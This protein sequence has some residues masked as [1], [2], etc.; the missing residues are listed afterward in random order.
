[1][2]AVT[3]EL[4]P[5]SQTTYAGRPFT[6]DLYA[7]ANPSQSIGVVNVVLRWDPTFLTLL[8]QDADG[9]VPW[10]T[11][12]FPTGGLN[13][14]FSDGDAFFTAN[15]APC[16]PTTIT[17]GGVRLTTL[18]FVAG[19]TPGTGQASASAS[20]GGFQS[21]A[22]DN[23]TIL[24]CNGQPVAVSVGPAVNI[25][26]NACISSLNCNDGDACSADACSGGVCTYSPN[27]NALTHCCNPA[28]GAQTLINDGN[29]C[30]N[31]LCDS[32]TG[33]VTHSNKTFGSA[34]GSQVQNSCTNP[35]TC[36][37]SG[38]CLANNTTN[39]APCDDG[40]TCSQS[41]S[42]QGGVCTGANPRPNGTACSD[43]LDCTSG[44]G[45]CS[46]GKCIEP[47]AVCGG[48]TPFCIETPTC[49]GSA[50]CGAQGP[51]TGGIC[52]AGYVCWGCL[53]EPKP[54]TSNADC[55]SS[56][57]CENSVC[58][59]CA[60]D[61]GC[62]TRYCSPFSH[63]CINVRHHDQCQDSVFC[64]G[65]E[66]CDIF[67]S[68]QPANPPEA[69]CPPGTVCN[70][71]GDDC[72]ECVDTSNCPTG[73]YCNTAAHICVD[74]L[75]NAHCN[76]GNSCNGIET[77]NI[78]SGV[79]VAGSPVVCSQTQICTINVCNPSNGLCEPRAAE[80]VSCS[81]QNPCPQGFICGPS[82]FCVPGMSCTDNNGC[83]VSDT[84]QNGACVGQP[85]ASNGPVNLRLAPAAGAVFT[86]GQ[87]VEVRYSLLAPT[88]AQ[89][90]NTAEANLQWDQ[91]RLSLQSPGFVDPCT[92]HS[93]NP[94]ACPAGQYDWFSSGFLANLDL[95]GLN[96]SFTDGNAHYSA[97]IGPGLPDAPV[98]PST[99]L[100]VTSFK[101]TA[102]GAT[103]STG[104]Q[105]SLVRCTGP[106]GTFSRVSAG[107][108]NDLTG[109]FISTTINIQCSNNNQC[110]D[111]NACTIDSCNLGTQYCQYTNSANGI[112]CGNQTPT[113]NCDLPDIC[114]A[115]VCNP[116]HTSCADD[117]NPC[118]DDVC[119]AAT[120]NCVRPSKPNGTPCNDGQ[121]CTTG[122]TCS[123]GACG[124]GQPRTC[125]DSFS[126]TIDSCNESNDSCVH[127]PDD[128]AC[129][130][131]LFCN[132]Q[133]SCSVTQGCI[134]GTPPN[135]T[136]DGIACTQ[137]DFCNESL[138]LCDGVPNN[139]LCP[140]GQIC[141]ALIGCLTTNC[142]PPLA[143]SA[144]PRY[145]VVTPQP[146]G[147]TSPQ[148]LNIDSLTWTCLSKYVG[149]PV[150]VDIN[151]DGVIDGKAAK[152][153]DDPG[154]AA[155][156][157]PAQWGGTVYIT[158]E[159]IVPTDRIPGGNPPISE[160]TYRVTADCG[161]GEFSLP[162][163]VT[164][165]FWA[166]ADHNGVVNFTDVSLAVQ[167]FL[168]R[169]GLPPGSNPGSTKLSV[170]LV[171][172]VPC[173]PPVP[174]LVN[175][176]DIS[177]HIRSF[178]GI[179]YQATILGLPPGDGCMMPCP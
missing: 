94:L 3:F 117:G 70:E 140:S 134:A 55:P 52:A 28:T 103:S 90:I 51:C 162:T 101:F 65:D 136:S 165:D 139:T 105:V 86:I 16:T 31:D 95:D 135:C 19:T 78:S 96:D 146:V 2:A 35:D 128:G 8:G 98:S 160:S 175:F 66:V 112:A 14:S 80:I 46:G 9:A 23:L 75:S 63:V 58:R 11:A 36:D 21:A 29:S 99:P 26:I 88:T 41:S 13:A 178:Q 123:A 24:N 102:T 44:A 34:C 147:S 85:P 15:V 110:N 5:S 87:T 69:D 59:N 108:G 56:R 156:L 100:W 124:G 91:A 61:A 166:D 27:Y 38:N 17:A 10:Q 107:S 163:P 89:N 158:G 25:T 111:G 169:F 74:C 64:N 143:R 133:E 49:A 131:Y 7:V 125:S 152:L 12:G 48:S 72:V 148:A 47:N 60:A 116:N 119:D 62:V 57:P 22:W 149:T 150:D 127:T 120:G 118:T 154:N 168:G 164:M 132:G 4:R 53:P 18:E 106:N 142:P 45:T 37:A 68:C 161:A 171:G 153:V 20:F 172:I 82:G 104:T 174:P 170:D 6:I 114:M 71:A 1:M 137:N 84:C 151:G 81:Q 77:C 121:F 109:Q 159:D 167:A 176:S 179:S 76:D 138:N 32:S 113:G 30:T 130:D 144:G 50:E 155:M 40:D 115:G 97:L 79:C 42:C 129:N 173:D 54:C 141:V 33:V 122:E 177:Q 83:T 93:S 39:G 92:N 145:I 126:C 67:G 73:R 157:T 43:G